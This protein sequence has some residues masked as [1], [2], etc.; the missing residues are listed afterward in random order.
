M[1]VLIQGPT[2]RKEKRASNIE[3]IFDVQLYKKHFT[4]DGFTRGTSA[5]Q[6]RI[7]I[8]LKL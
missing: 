5:E 8:K 1:P 6:N 4:E 7:K 2:T 3:D